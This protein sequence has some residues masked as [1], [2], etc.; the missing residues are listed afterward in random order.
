MKDILQKTFFGKHN[1]V[2]TE[3]YNKL[4]TMYKKN[5]FI[6]RL[7][8]LDDI[9]IKLY[10][11]DCL[12]IMPKLNPE[13]I[14]C[15]ITDL[16]Y[17]RTNNIWDT[18]I[19]FDQ[20]WANYERITKKRCTI[21]LFADGLFMAKLMLSNENNWKY[22]LIWDK[23]LASGFLN[24]NKQPLRQHENIVVFYS[25]KQ[26]TYN[27]Q[28]TIG[29]KNH[30]TGSRKFI[31]N[32]NYNKFELVDNSDKLGDMKHPKSI[33][34]FQKPHPSVALHPTQKPLDLI[35]Y[36]VKT[37]SNE[38][39]TILDNCMGSGTTGVACRNL[40]RN[41]IGIEKDENYFNMAKKRIIDCYDGK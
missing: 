1:M 41:F 7:N 38:G 37:Y 29:L 24:A 6:S 3:K 30:S 15:I 5:S 33:L 26:P 39:D 13:S 22:N 18:I 2:K 28:K 8:S 14:D 16:P 35:E 12:D 11:G 31:T 36:L 9:D 32:N 25:D 21:L 20:L 40:H 10:Q 17:G 4:F 34:T 19:P 27:P 23:V